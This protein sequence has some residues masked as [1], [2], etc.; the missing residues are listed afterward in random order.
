LARGKRQ[1]FDKRQKIG[2][3]TTGGGDSPG[4]GGAHWANCPPE[5]AGAEAAQRAAGA[6]AAAGRAAGD[7]PSAPRRRQNAAGRAESPAHAG[8]YSFLLFKS[9]CT[10]VS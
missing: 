1:F 5:A 8:S 3:F 2:V 10:D 7:A 9:S 6:E 4:R